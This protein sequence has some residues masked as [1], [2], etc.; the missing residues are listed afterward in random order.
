MNN[1]TAQ[2]SRFF[3]RIFRR[4]RNRR[5]TLHVGITIAVPPFVK[6]VIDYENHPVNDNPKPRAPRKRG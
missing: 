5:S 4:R 6:V 1:L 2:V 3:A